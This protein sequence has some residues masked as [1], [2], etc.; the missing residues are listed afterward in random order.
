M[1]IPGIPRY[2]MVYLI[3]TNIYI[4][5]C[6]L[7]CSPSYLYVL[8]FQRWLTHVQNSQ[9]FLFS[10]C[11]DW[12]YRLK[13]QPNPPGFLGLSGETHY[14][15]RMGPLAS[16]SPHWSSWSFVTP[17]HGNYTLEL[18]PLWAQDSSHHQD[19]SIFRE[20]QPKPSFLTGILGW[21]VD[22]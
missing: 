3:N 22:G 10:W 9:R 16:K 17:K 12:T 20:S 6:M 4:Q 15:I 21:G 2:T 5:I 19:R 11:E 1:G 8:N 18:P 13:K 14:K 7:L